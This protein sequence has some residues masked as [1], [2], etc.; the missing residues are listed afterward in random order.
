M[1]AEAMRKHGGPFP[2]PIPPVIRQLLGDGGGTWEQV[3]KL[4]ASDLDMLCR[5]YSNGLGK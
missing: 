3:R 2:G 1:F 4:P 5:A